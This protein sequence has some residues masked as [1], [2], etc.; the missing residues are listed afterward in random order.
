MRTVIAISCWMW[1][2]VLLAGWGS[3]QGCSQLSSQKY[4]M[5]MNMLAAAVPASYD[6]ATNFC[7]KQQEIVTREAEAGTITSDVAKERIKPIRAECD[8]V[9]TSYVTIKNLYAAA[10]RA[11][12]A[13]QDGELDRLLEQI[14]AAWAPL[15]KGGSG[16]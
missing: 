12:E 16:S 3:L 14:R 7:L 2:A 8:R 9:D 15:T 10:K 4:A 13:H 5:T 6:V 1:A 11:Y